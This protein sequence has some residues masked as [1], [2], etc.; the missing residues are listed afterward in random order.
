MQ[1][2]KNAM[3]IEQERLRRM[4]DS[5]EQLQRELEDKKELAEKATEKSVNKILEQER[6]INR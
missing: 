4:I 5:N 2:A 1:D 6:R 3:G